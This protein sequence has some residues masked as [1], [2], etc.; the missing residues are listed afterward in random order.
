M[1][2]IALKQ[3]SAMSVNYQLTVTDQRVRDDVSYSETQCAFFKSTSVSPER[4]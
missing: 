3:R 2:A 4:H 1:L